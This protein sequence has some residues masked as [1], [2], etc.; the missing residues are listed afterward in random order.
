MMNMKPK[1]Y[2]RCQ[3]ILVMDSTSSGRDYENQAIYA[4]SL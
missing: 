3:G 2:M 1:I 4:K